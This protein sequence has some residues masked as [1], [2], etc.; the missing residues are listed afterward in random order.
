MYKTIF[1]SQ[2]SRF[3]IKPQNI[4]AGKDRIIS[5]PYSTI[6]ISQF[7]HIDFREAVQLTVTFATATHQQSDQ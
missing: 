1:Q 2:F 4:I 5:N 7:Y 6:G 3:L